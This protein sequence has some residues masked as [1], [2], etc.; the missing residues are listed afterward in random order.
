MVH[1]HGEPGVTPF[2][3]AVLESACAATASVE[4]ANGV[5][6][7]HAVRTAAVGDHFDVCGKV[8]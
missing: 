5:V 7:E 8:S 6:G 2:G 4:K 3:E 1:M